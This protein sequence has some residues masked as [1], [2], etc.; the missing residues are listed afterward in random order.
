MKTAALVLML[1]VAA[2]SLAMET[3]T[4]RYE[5]DGT[6]FEGY[7]AVDTALE[8]KRPVVLVVHEWWGLS[9][10]PKGHPREGLVV[11]TEYWVHGQGI[12]AQASQRDIAAR[13][14]VSWRDLH[15]RA[16]AR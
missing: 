15:R 3:E 7:L 5:H 8:G 16:A 1:A 2:S 12:D 13:C 14:K 4:I 10:A 11:A 9:Y 6:T